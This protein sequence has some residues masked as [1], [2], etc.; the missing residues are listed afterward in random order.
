MS[1]GKVESDLA[2]LVAGTSV[3]IDVELSNGL[4]VNV[5]PTK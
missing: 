1:K 4:T 3:G 2:D 5:K